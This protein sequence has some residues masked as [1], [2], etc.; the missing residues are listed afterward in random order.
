VANEPSGRALRSEPGQC[1]VVV[2][3]HMP[4][5]TAIAAAGP[6][7]PFAQTLTVIPSTVPVTPWTPAPTPVASVVADA[8]AIDVAA[9]RDAAIADGL[10][11]GRAQGLAEGQALRTQLARLVDAMNTATQQAAQHASEKISD[12]AM[13]VIAAWLGQAPSLKPVIDAWTAKTSEPA[14]ARVNPAD[15][16]ALGEIAGLTVVADA[17]IARGDIQL[18]SASHELTHTWSERL[19]EL[20]AAIQASL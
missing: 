3:D 14:T 13:T 17:T 19:V 2:K 5:L 15:V 8:P 6:P 4:F 10:A 1:E 12:A 11:Q 16:E 7:R 18:R 20:R 9:I